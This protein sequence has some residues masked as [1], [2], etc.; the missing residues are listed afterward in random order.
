MSVDILK[1][2]FFL[3]LKIHKGNIIVWIFKK[4][5]KQDLLLAKFER[6]I[7]NANEK[8]LYMFKAFKPLNLVGLSGLS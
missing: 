7:Y 6:K 3:F 4:T 8:C 5:S 2:I 1:I